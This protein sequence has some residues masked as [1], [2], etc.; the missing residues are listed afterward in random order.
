M[1]SALSWALLLLLLLNALQKRLADT[2]Y[3]QFVDFYRNNRLIPWLRFLLNRL[4]H[5]GD[6]AICVA[7][8]YKV[9]RWFRWIKCV[10]RRIPPPNATLSFELNVEQCCMCVCVFVRRVSFVFSAKSTIAKWGGE[11]LIHN[12]P[13]GNIIA[14][15]TNKGNEGM[16]PDDWVWSRRKRKGSEEEEEEKNGE[17][18][19]NVFKIEDKLT[20]HSRGHGEGMISLGIQRG[21]REE[22]AAAGAMTAVDLRPLT[23]L[24]S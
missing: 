5:F 8:S 7:R 17:R 15:P 14:D 22:F 13:G 18:K 19:R 12:K 16:P 20:S 9:V 3:G 2:L 24:Y 10:R 4:T 6:H 21:E 11:S 23:S 1:Y